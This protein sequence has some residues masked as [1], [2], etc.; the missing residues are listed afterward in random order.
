MGV[1]FVINQKELSRFQEL[2]QKTLGNA[3]S[4]FKI[5]LPGNAICRSGGQISTIDR[6][7]DPQTGTIRVRV[8]FPNV[9]RVLK[10]GMSCNL[11]ILNENSGL[12]VMIPYKAVVEQMGEYFVYVVNGKEANQVKIA[13][14]AKLGENIIVREGLEAEKIIV[15]DGVQ[16]LHD[17]SPVQVGMPKPEGSRNHK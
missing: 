14:G 4:T 2:E 12:Q 11:D 16:K 15:T 8:T 6:A 9:D 13:L 17:G 10:A 5:L 3:D 7:V 1:D